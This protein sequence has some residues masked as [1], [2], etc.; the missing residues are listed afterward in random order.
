MRAAECDGKKRT[1][2]E[3]LEVALPAL[4]ALAEVELRPNGGHGQPDRQEDAHLDQKDW[5]GAVCAGSKEAAMRWTTTGTSSW[6]ARPQVAATGRRGAARRAVSQR[7]QI[8]DEVA[9]G[10]SIKTQR[11]SDGRIDFGGGS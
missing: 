10:N 4:E 8:V 5:R 1:L 2:L 11:F 6:W 3:V 9:I 7:W